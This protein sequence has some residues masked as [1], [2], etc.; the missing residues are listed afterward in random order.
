MTL[1]PEMKAYA[2]SAGQQGALPARELQE[3]WFATRRRDWRTLAVVPASPG[4]SILPIARALADV[5]SAI[6]TSPVQV[7][8]AEGMDFNKIAL[9]VMHM[10]SDARG[11]AARAAW[12]AGE[13]EKAMIVAIDAVVSNPLVLPIALAADAVLL[14]VGLNETKLEAARHTVELIGRSRLVG[15]VLLRDR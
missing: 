14:C 9:L 1:G 10:T 4:F 7:V 11:A 13:S 3:L 6:R 8:R 12:T 15:S 5:G 2:E